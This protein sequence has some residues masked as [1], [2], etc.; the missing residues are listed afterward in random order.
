MELSTNYQ[1]NPNPLNVIFFFRRCTT[2]P[3]I[4]LYQLHWS[5]H[6]VRLIF[7]LWRHWVTTW[8]HILPSTG[9]MSAILLYNHCKKH[10]TEFTIK[11]SR[12]AWYYSQMFLHI[13]IHPVFDN[14]DIQKDSLLVEG[15]QVACWL[16]SHGTTAWV[17][18]C[19]PVVTIA[20]TWNSEISIFSVF[21]KNQIMEFI[22]K[23]RYP[24]CLWTRNEPILHSLHLIQGDNKFNIGSSCLGEIRFL[25]GLF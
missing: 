3:T 8:S 16:A 7:A 13:F 2:I 23:C 17:P 15:W 4:M 1:S 18:G 9:R 6:L 14:E 25:F 24:T 19:L 21:R 10:F 20:A 12:R 22:I 5:S 11:L